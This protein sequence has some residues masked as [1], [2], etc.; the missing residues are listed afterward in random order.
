VDRLRNGFLPSHPIFFMTIL[1]S[2]IAKKKMLENK[3]KELPDEDVFRKT[4][5]EIF[6]KLQML[7]GKLDEDTLEVILQRFYGDLS[8]KEL[9]DMRKEP[10]GTT[11]SKVHRGL[12]KLRELMG[13][14]RG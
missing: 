3:A 9:A 10:I 4:E 12:K 1:G 13:D 8:F 14:D 6:D 2:N 5:P 7:L 11:L